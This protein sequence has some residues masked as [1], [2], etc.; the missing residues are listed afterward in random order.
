MGEY[1]SGP[2]QNEVEFTLFGPGY[3]E[4]IAVHL[5]DGAWLLVDSCIRPDNGLPASLDYLQKV[6][7]SPAS[8]KAIVASHWHD[9]HVRGISKLAQEYPDA[10]FILSGVFNDIEGTAFLAAYGSLIA[11]PQTA[12]AKELYQVVSTKAGRLYFAANRSAI[13]DATIQNRRVR[14][15][16]FSP[17]TKAQT[18]WRLRAISFLPQIPG[19]P[20][21]HAP[22]LKPNVEAIAIHIDFGGDAILLGSDLE[23]DGDLGWAAVVNDHV[24][25]GQTRSSAYKVAHHGSKSGDHPEIWTKLLTSEAVASLTP[26]NKGSNNL[27]TIDDRKRIKGQV[28]SAFISS[29]ASKR[30]AIPGDQLKRL[31][32]ICKNVATVNSGFGAVRFRKALGQTSWGVQLFGNAQEL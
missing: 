27:P 15:L 19:G 23:D 13:F 3:G 4:A 28:R 26:F 14:V 30:P 10:E 29:S 18:E 32:D 31:T 17:T 2:A 7:V 11:A 22:E 8:V 5:G 9:D 24:C 20:I 1:G 16:A 12:G 21:N 6:N 25:V